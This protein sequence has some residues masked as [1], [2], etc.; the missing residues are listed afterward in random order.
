MA[1]GESGAKHLT[2]S[3]KLGAPGLLAAAPCTSLPPAQESSARL[4]PQ[5]ALLALFSSSHTTA[6]F[7]Q[8]RAISHG[9]S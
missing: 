9:R 4:S 5:K 7:P 1:G 3:K 8:E 6:A 2:H